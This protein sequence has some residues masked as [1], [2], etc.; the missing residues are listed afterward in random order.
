[1]TL[2]EMQEAVHQTAREHGWWDKDS[3]TDPNVVAAKLALIHSEVSEALEE[4]RSAGTQATSIS[5]GGKPEGFVV[6]LADV[7]IRIGD[8]CGAL[9]IDLE[10]A[11]EAKMAYNR[12]RPYRHGGKAL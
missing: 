12:T 6:E 7:V 3:I 9:G 4:V 11:V 10:R 8:L 1:M 2:R 5:E